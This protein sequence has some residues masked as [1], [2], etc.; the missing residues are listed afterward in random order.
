MRDMHASRPAAIDTV[1]VLPYRMIV[2]EGAT[3]PSIE[4]IFFGASGTRSFASGH[5][6]EV[7]RERW[8]MRYLRDDADQAFVAVNAAGVVVG[9]LVGALHDPAVTGRFGDIAYFKGFAPLTKLYPAHLHIN[10]APEFRGAGLGGRLIEAF[11]A[12]ASK[13]GCPGM[14]VVTGGASRNVGFYT[15]RGFKEAGRAGGDKPVVFLGRKL[16][17]TAGGTKTPG[18]KR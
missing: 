3:V 4:R 8:L 2:G 16:G 13:A 15:A 14:H 1:E 5:A 7:F 18:A 12:H 10:F 17:Q 6:R 11:A 9:Y